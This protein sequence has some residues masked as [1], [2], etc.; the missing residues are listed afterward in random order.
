M[1]IL[2]VVG[3]SKH[4]LRYNALAFSIL[5]P[6]FAVRVLKEE[7]TSTSSIL[8]GAQSE[9]TLMSGR[10]QLSTGQSILFINRSKEAITFNALEIWFK[11]VSLV[12]C[13]AKIIHSAVCPPKTG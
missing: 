12:S 4:R 10:P 6:S 9:G 7:R 1:D 8:T 3:W 11:N 13:H 5:T 2:G